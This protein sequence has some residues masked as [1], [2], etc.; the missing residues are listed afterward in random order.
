M[1]M[2][3]PL[4][5]RIRNRRWRCLAM[6]ASLTLSGCS[7]IPAYQR[8]ALPVPVD[9]ASAVVPASNT[10]SAVVLSADEEALAGELSPKG[11]LRRL[12]Q[13]ALAFNRDFR[14]AVLRVEEARAMRGITRADRFPTL[15]AGVERDRQHF[16]NAAADERYGQDIS[17]ASVGVSDFEL[18][19]FGRVR[20][21]SEAARHDYLASTYGQQ[22]ARSALIA[23]VARAWLAERLAAAVQQDAQA[24][25]EAR[26]MLVKAAEEQQRQ[27]ALSLDDLM[28]QRLDTLSAQQQV[29]DAASDHANASQALLLLTGYSTVLPVSTPDTPALTTALVETPSWLSNLPS[30][31]LLERFDIRQREEALKASNANIGAARAAFFPSIKLSTGV[32]LQSDSLRTL[33]SN[34]SGAWLFTPQLNLPLFDGGRNQANLD[35]AKVRQQIAVAEY[36]KAVQNAFREMSAVLTRRQQALNHVRNEV[37]RVALVQEKV[38]RLSFE[39]NAGAV[40]RTA[41]LVSTLRIAEADAAARQSL[42]ALQQN[43]IDLFRVLHGAEP[44]TPPQS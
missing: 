3:T 14:V 6:L 44:T 1:P 19:F 15:A 40:E 35:L 4:S 42:D 12:L 31:R 37:E 18:D 38:R 27:G 20:S 23:E 28:A 8:P 9:Q 11:E 13:S 10:S 22:A 34:G 24:V 25:H 29:Q 26:L 43:R 41:L 17:I 32:G 5:K 2:S 16:D 30:Q 7:L 21:L 33:F 36:E 39:L